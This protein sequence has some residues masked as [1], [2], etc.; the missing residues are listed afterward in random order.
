MCMVSHVHAWL[1]ILFLDGGAPSYYLILLSVPNRL[2]N[3]V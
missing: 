1:L 3:D 2:S